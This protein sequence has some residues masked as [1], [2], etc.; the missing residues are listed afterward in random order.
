M[1]MIPVKDD[2][3]DLAST[4]TVIGSTVM[5]GAVLSGIGS[6]MCVETIS[7]AGKQILLRQN[8]KEE[9]DKRRCVLAVKYTIPIYN[10]FVL[11]CAEEKDK[12]YNV[13]GIGKFY[14]KLF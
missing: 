6:W 3:K 13:C 1:A 9:V 12:P 7:R 8:K 11:R 14:S 4:C 10:L 2:V 5:A